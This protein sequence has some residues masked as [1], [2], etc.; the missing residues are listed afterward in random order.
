LTAIKFFG[1][2]NSNFCYNLNPLNEGSQSGKG[3]FVCPGPN[4]KKLL[5]AVI[6]RH[7]MVIPSFCVINNITLVITIEWQL[8]TIGIFIILNLPCNDGKLLQ[9]DSKLPRYFNPDPMVNYHGIFTTLAAGVNV[10]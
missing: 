3:K 5:T 6:Y 1:Q 10:M 4:V 7:S 9:Y 8:I 2:S